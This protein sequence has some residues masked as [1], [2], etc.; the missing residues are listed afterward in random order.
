MNKKTVIKFHLLL[1]CQDEITDIRFFNKKTIF[2][3][4]HQFS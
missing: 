3:P 1:N 2:L 4:E